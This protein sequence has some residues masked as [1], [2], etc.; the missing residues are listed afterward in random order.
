MADERERARWDTIC[1][2]LRT[3]LS[4]ILGYSDMLLEDTEELPAWR[5]R[6]AQVR[7]VREAGQVL[8]HILDGAM[9]A[10]RRDGG[11]EPFLVASTRLRG[12][13]RGP[14]DS[15]LTSMERLVEETLATTVSGDLLIDLERIR[16][17]GRR[18]DALM[19]ELL[20]APSADAPADA[21][22]R[23]VSRPSWVP[24][25]TPEIITRSDSVAPPPGS[26]RAVTGKLLVVDD[27]ESNRAV[28]SQRLTRQGHT[29]SAASGG[30]EALELLGKELFDLVLLDVMMPDMDGY[31]VLEKMKSDAVLR[32]L[33]VV[34]I[35]ARGDLEGMVRCLELGAEDYLAKPFNPVL[36]RARIGASLA[37][38]QQRDRERFYVDKLRAA[39]QQSEALLLNVLPKAIADRLKAGESDIADYFPAVTVLF[40]DLVG[41]TAYAARLSPATVVE[42]LNEI[43]SAF[44]QLADRHGVEK[45]KTIGDAYLAVGGLPVPREDHAD[46]IA[47]LALDMQ[48]E[49]DRFNDRTGESIVI[50]TGIHSGPVVA[51]IIGTKKFTYDLWG[52][53]VNTASRMESHGV[54]GAIQ[55][56]EATRLLLAG[57]YAVTPR[58]AIDVKGKGMMETS[59]LT[60]RK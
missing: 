31:Q 33:P 37:Q 38:K 22:P 32:H 41:F 46:A 44:D 50:R 43:F 23:P 49:V 4:I 9:T 52:D 7:Q 34:M 57:K 51:G 54:P 48:I 8:L 2:D 60:G 47:E 42:R 3:P 27:N 45:I 40:A 26:I 36:L 28:L 13:L 56:S 35:S 55:I 18:F 17:A 14:L 21:T 5:A 19:L 1:H 15:V 30:R 10:S 24:P 6:A 25:P 11:V 58:G 16:T 39:Q 53:T 12:D 59:L 20:P 29:V